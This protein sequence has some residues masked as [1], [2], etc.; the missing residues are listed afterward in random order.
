MSAIR[1][2]APSGVLEDSV[3]SPDN[4][5]NL[6]LINHACTVFLNALCVILSRPAALLSNPFFVMLKKIIA[7]KFLF[8]EKLI[9]LPQH[10]QKILANCVKE[11]Y[12]C[13]EIVVL[14]L[15]EE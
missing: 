4:P 15:F 11:K 12:R 13:I 3:I 8:S 9:S 2:T 14:F 7:E 5:C 1:I 10:Y 6:L